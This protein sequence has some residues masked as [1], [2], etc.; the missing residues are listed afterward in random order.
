MLKGV[1]LKKPSEV[2]AGWVRNPLISPSI[3]QM[4]SSSLRKYIQRPFRLFTH[5]GQRIQK[6]S[7]RCP[8]GFEMHDLYFSVRPKGEAG[9]HTCRGSV[10]HSS[11]MRLICTEV[12]GMEGERWKDGVC[13]L[14]VCDAQCSQTWD[15]ML[16]LK[17]EISALRCKPSALTEG[18]SRECTREQKIGS[19]PP[20]SFQKGKL[21]LN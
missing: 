1:G 18:R 20:G 4:H 10:D 12:W 15:Q 16:R 13:Y 19:L 2:P 7:E 8:R 21:F 14:P 5:V 3:S 11:P 17:A 9:I 6:C